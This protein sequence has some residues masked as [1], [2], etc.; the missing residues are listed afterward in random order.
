MLAVSQSAIIREMSVQEIEAELTELHLKHGNNISAWPDDII[1]LGE[2][3]EYQLEQ[4]T[5]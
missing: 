5:A 4:L 2:E 3:L 1:D